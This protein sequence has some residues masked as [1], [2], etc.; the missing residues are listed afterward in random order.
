MRIGKHNYIK[1]LKLHNEKALMYVIDEY[2]GLIMSV[3][4]RHLFALPEQ[5]EECFDDVLLRIWQ[6]IYDFDESKNS[7]KNWSAAIAK[8]RAID[9]LRQY[10]REPQTVDIDGT[11]IAQED[12]MLTSVIEKEISKEVEKML[13]CLKP[14]DRELF[15]RLYVK[16][17]DME[18]ISRETGLKK[19]VIY[20]RVSRGKRKIRK[21]CNIG[22][23]A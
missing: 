1:Q 17:Q 6:H 23:G 13:A 16:E 4:R 9:Y 10:Q 12:C 20:N 11:V 14:S 15:I 18:Q 2:G 22:R 7:F 19:E 8:Y 5:Q 3:I 21:Q